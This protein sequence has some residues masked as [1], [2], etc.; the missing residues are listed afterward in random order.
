MASEITKRDSAFFNRLPAWHGL[1]ITKDGITIDD[2]MGSF[3]YPIVKEQ[4]Y[5]FAGEP[6]DTYATIRTLASGKRI[7]LGDKLSSDYS[8]LQNADLIKSVEPLLQAGC[9]LETGLTMS[10]GRRVCVL[11]NLPGDLV[12]GAGDCIKRY[13]LISN[14]HTGKQSARVGFTPIR[15]VCANTLGMAHYSDASSLIKIRHKGDM[16]VQVDCVVN[17]MDTANAQFIA[18]GDSLDRLT[19]VGINQHDLDKYVKRIFFPTLEEPKADATTKLKEAFEK[20]IIQLKK[21]QSTVSEVF[22]VEDSIIDHK[23]TNG[24][25][26]GAYQAVNFYLNHLRVGGD[27]KRLTSL[28]WGQAAQDE[29]RALKEAQLLTV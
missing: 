5:T 12:I 3:G 6:V 19:G 10:E 23:D 17:L 25:V 14:D 27:E 21:I 11:L 2:L 24:T 8:V 9:T 18:Y 20:K 7:I 28:V 26:Y 4:L 29:S 13:I 15:V 22:Q 16:G 1:G